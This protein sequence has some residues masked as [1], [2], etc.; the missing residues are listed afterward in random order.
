MSA[1]LGYSAIT[2]S[3]VEGLL[4]LMLYKNIRLNRFGL[5]FDR[6][7]SLETLEKLSF[8]SVLIGFILLTIAIIIGGIWLPTAFPDFNYFDPKLIATSLVWIIYGIGISSKL[9]ANW[10]GKKVIIFSLAGFITA[11]LSM[12]LTSILAES[13]HTFY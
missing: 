6:L 9:I 10:Y 13:F 4:F 5:I 1:L 11:I 2:I 7:P 12:L 3:A 8:Y